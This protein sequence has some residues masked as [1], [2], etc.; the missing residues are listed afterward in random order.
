MPVQNQAGLNQGG[1]NQAG[2]NQG[3]INP[4]LNK[5]N[6]QMPFGHLPNTGMKRVMN[7]YR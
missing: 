2:L 5:M 7:Y 6:P 1:L 4:G 3:G